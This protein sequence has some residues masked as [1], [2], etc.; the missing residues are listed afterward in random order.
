MSAAVRRVLWVWLLIVIVTALYWPTALSYSLLWTDLDNRGYTHGF[1]IAAMC[2]ALIYMRRDELTGP[3][4][5]PA[6]GAYV[7]LALLGLGWLLAYRAGIQ[8]AHQLLFPIIL[9]TAIYVVFGPRVGRSC[10]FAVAFVYFALPIWGIIN[11]ALQALT[12]AA[13]HLILLLIGLP[14]RFD[15]NLVAI[16][17]GT[18][19]IEGG[20]SGLHF[21]VVGLAI[22]AYYGELHRDTLRHRALL[23]GLAGAL[24]LLSNWI[25]V[26]VIIEAGHLTDMQSYLVRV[27][28]YGFGWA[29]FA[30]AITVFFLLASR[31]P[32]H[33]TQTPV[34]SAV[35]GVGA[36]SWP[37]GPALVLACSALALAP[38]LSWIAMRGDAAALAA[39]LRP[40][41]VPGWSGPLAPAST[42][43]PIFMGADSERF[44]SYRQGASAVEWY[45]AD[46]AFQRQGRKLLG[47]YNSIL[48]KGGFTVLDQGMQADAG[49]R[50]VTLQLRDQEGA[51][52]LVWYA[53]K[54]GEQ[55][56]TSGLRAQLWYGV[57]SLLGPVDSQIV[58]FR[59]KCEPDCAAAREQLRVF[60]ASICDTTSRFYN[61]R[62]DP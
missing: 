55:T 44:A 47:Y 22:A 51:Q 28:H 49:Q 50:F 59:A 54:I 23:L 21:M 19:A 36:G 34:D 31:L 12:I 24:A 45:T 27:S 5:R 6:R 2:L 56:M 46:Y 39:T 18:F 41:H 9:W 7:A 35:A 40:V 13:T 61:C 37:S 25:R 15:G 62:R 1:L 17:E 38:A 14:V 53:Y 3:M 52:S 57:T 33:P 32:A 29:V 60:V 43:R 30:V 8:S 10:L 58:A 4:P 20:C 16:P 26:S 42:W 11:G 48:G